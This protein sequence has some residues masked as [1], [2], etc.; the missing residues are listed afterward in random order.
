MHSTTNPRGSAGAEP[1][2]TGFRSGAG[3]ASK[4]IP[5][6]TLVKSDVP[7]L[8]GGGTKNAGKAEIIGYSG[9][10]KAPLKKRVRRDFLWY[11]RVTLDIFPPSWRLLARKPGHGQQQS[12]PVYGH[13]LGGWHCLLAAK[14]C[15]QHPLLENLRDDNG[16]IDT[17]DEVGKGDRF[18]TAPL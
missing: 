14:K 6:A 17:G 16:R 3:C 2:A 18:E 11:E 4:C 13:T 1:L 10:M 12:A 8:F 9:H 15:M 7:N 5:L